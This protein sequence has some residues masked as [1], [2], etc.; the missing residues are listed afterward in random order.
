[1]RIKPSRFRYISLLRRN[2]LFGWLA[3]IWAVVGVLT[4]VRDNFLSQELQKRYATLAL[5]PRL[6]WFYATIL[7]AILLLLVLESSYQIYAQRCFARSLGNSERALHEALTN[8][9]G[10][11]RVG[12]LLPVEC[13]G[14]F[15]LTERR[16]FA[17]ELRALFERAGWTV[18]RRNIK[19]EELGVIEDDGILLVYYSPNKGQNEPDYGF[20]ETLFSESGISSMRQGISQRG[21]GLYSDGLSTSDFLVYVGPRC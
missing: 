18:V 3:A 10:T 5:L 2:R 6:G 21:Q 1:M 15:D 17:K 12:I 4:F 13:E 14:E 9:S 7:L 20:L 11:K 19:K 16:G 8:Y